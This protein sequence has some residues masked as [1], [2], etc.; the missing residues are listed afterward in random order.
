MQAAVTKVRIGKILV[1]R[2]A[3]KDIL[4][5]V[6]NA[7]V[8]RQ[9]R[10]IFYA[11][12]YGVTLAEENPNFAAS[13]RGA[14]YIFCD[15]FGVYAASRALGHSIPE[16]FAWPDWINELAETA[17]A[18]GASMFFLGAQQ[19]VATVAAKKLEERVPGLTVTAHHGHFPKDEASSLAVIE[20]INASGAEV[21]LVGFGMPLQE[22]WVEKFR[23][24][25]R[26]S[27]VFTA[28]A[29]FDYVA[30]HVRRGPPI[31]TQYGF[32][33][34]TRLLIEPRRLWRRYLVGLPHF[35]AV[36]AEQWVRERF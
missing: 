22:L 6:R 9:R 17:H 10:T 30:G 21:L 11:N 1:D 2:M 31:L 20:K 14:D 16:R 3:A 13:M 36:I 19:G 34:L 12:A 18:A 4:A 8:S 29:L 25:L 32:E 7:L 24:Q 5:V 23:E 35:S 33:W 27:V 28:G 15:G 26:P